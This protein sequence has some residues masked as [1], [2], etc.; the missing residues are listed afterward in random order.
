MNLK[1]ILTSLIERIRRLP[2]AR[3]IKPL[4]K[5]ALKSLVQIEGDALQA[6]LK[7]ALCEEGSKAI[8]KN[9]DRFQASIKRGLVLLPLH[10]EVEEKLKVAVQEEGDKLQEKLHAAVRDGCPG[11]LDAACDALQATLMARIDAL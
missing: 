8:D 9:I 3:Y 4:Y 5:G 1:A 11:A 2:I 6:R 10:A 7:V